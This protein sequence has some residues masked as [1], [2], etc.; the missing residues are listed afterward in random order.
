M[1]D[2][3]VAARQAARPGWRTRLA[4]QP[5]AVLAGV[6]A[7][8]YIVTAM[9]DDSLLTASGVRSVLL[10]ACPLAIF[11]ASQTL[12]MLTGGIDLSIA[13]T[14][15]F[16]AY[17]A[18]NESH[19]G[20]V[21]ALSMALAV[22]LAVGAVNGLAI[23]VF[24]VNPLIMTL[25]MASVLLGV[26][27]VGLRGWLSGSTRVLSVVRDVGSGKLI[28]PLPNNLVVWAVV[29][30]LLVLGL[31]SSGL[32]RTIYAIGD[33]PIACRLAGVRVWQVLLAVYVIAGLLA[34]VGGLLF[35]GTTGSVGVDQTNSYLLPSVAATVIGGTS[36]LGGSGGY[37]GTIIGA[38]ILTV[39]NR[40][41]LRLEVSEAFKQM[42]YGVIVLALAWLYVRLTGQKVAEGGG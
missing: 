10:L 21:A 13:M 40:L 25:G 26:V 16:A 38:L 5:T 19:R 27:T 34:A 28:G 4:E 9:K 30:A 37:S 1:T 20:P 23:G 24:K 6:L 15:N 31:R 2:V 41:L 39:L 8:L 29:A 18:A 22:G 32:G 3:V 36:I 42:L 12:C 35:S 17:V 7:V 14:A 33:N 11:A